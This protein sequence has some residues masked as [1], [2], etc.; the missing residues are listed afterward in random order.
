MFQT[1]AVTTAHMPSLSQGINTVLKIDSDVNNIYWSFTMPSC[2]LF[3]T[4]YI[5]DYSEPLSLP[6]HEA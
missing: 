1:Y 2:L 6:F 4:P 3:N 5:R